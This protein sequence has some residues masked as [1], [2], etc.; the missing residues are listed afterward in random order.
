MNNTGMNSKE[1]SSSAASNGP[2][3]SDLAGIAGVV[4]A[5]GLGTRLRPL[6]MRQPKP[7][8]SVAGKPLIDWAIDSMPLTESDIAVNASYLANQIEDHLR[9]R[10][11]HVEVEPEPLGSAG[12]IANLRSWID[13]R[14]VLI[15]NAD[16][17]F[18]E[19]PHE[20][21]QGWDRRNPRLLVSETGAQ[22]DFGTYRFLGWSL[23]PASAVERMSAGYGALYNQIWAPAYAHR[24]IEFVLYN[25]MAVDCGTLDDLTRA[26]ALAERKD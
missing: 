17:W 15:R 25:G 7:M 23:L 9:G 22:A 19:T 2:R 26:R 20:L 4:L 1:S 10:D 11:V 5:A 16:T 14:D 3:S 18:S 6:T 13:G 24:E 12:A 8:I 21:W